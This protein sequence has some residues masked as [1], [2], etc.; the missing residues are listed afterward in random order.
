VT[1]ESP[2]SPRPSRAAAASRP[3][4]APD[5]SP[6]S[7]SVVVCA[8]TN[9]RWDDIVA[10][11]AGIAAQSYPALESILVIDRN[12]QLLARALEAFPN[13]RVIENAGRGG[14]SGARN[15]GVAVASGV[16]DP[17]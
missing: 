5:T 3:E 7:V 2:R 16:P 1:P 11:Q 6:Q 17:R 8:H 14:A 10:G 12:P 13:V 9:D 15:T 4:A